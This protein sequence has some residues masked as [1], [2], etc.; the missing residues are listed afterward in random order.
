MFIGALL[1]TIG[2]GAIPAFVS[3]LAF[4]EQ[5]LKYPFLKPLLNYLDLTTSKQLLIYSGIALLVVFI[6]KNVFVSFVY[7]LQARFTKNRQND[8][9]HRLF[10]FYIN[11][12]YSFH[13]KNDSSVLLRNV[14]QETQRVIV[15]ILGPVQTIIMQSLILISISILLLAT[16]P[17]L[18]IFAGTILGLSS[19]LFLKVLHAK[20]K[21]VGQAAQNE[22]QMF[23][24]IINQGL[25][26][27]KEILVSGNN[28]YFTKKFLTSIRRITSADAFIL[29]AEKISQPF[30]ECIIVLGILAVAGIL[31]FMGRSIE[32]IAPTLALFGAA[33]I[34]LKNCMIMIVSSFTNLRYNAVAI[35]PVW[36][37]LN[38]ISKL[39]KPHSSSPTTTSLDNNIKFDKV[40]Y[41]YPGSDNPSIKEINLIIPKTG[42]IALVGP[43]GSGKTTLVDI[44]LG[45]LEPDKGTILENGV[46]INTNLAE[47]HRKIGYIPQ[48]IYLLNDT[49]KNNIAFGLED[50]EI[51]EKKLQKAIHTAQLKDFV[52]TLPKRVET[53]VGERGIR[54]SGGQ[55]QRIGIARA[56][57]NNP[58]ILVMDEATSALDN[59]TEDLLVQALEK[60]KQD[61]TIIMIA[62]R[63]STIKNCDVLYFMKDGH[64]I[65][66]GKY[67]ELLS[68]CDEFRKMV[69]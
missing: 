8:L 24:Q 52:S 30:L 35:N 45:L 46:D 56:L 9:S 59:T 61:R 57:Y 12:P 34:R 16:E 49:I 55:R 47:W 54:L 53:I 3:V 5:I 65:A 23:I 41:T 6:I 37:D 62:H 29:V 60:L 58:E 22:R 28:S 66:S 63:L 40:Q 11:A 21:K 38:T 31:L 19:G 43:T 2:V 32:S 15:G 27:I 10:A 18:T 68:K 50:S 20:T 48:F 14:H 67:D 64:I 26:G 69:K 1:E 13:L 4:P 7:Y 33:L 39:V 51:N 44:L 36:K 42:S 17:V 25:G